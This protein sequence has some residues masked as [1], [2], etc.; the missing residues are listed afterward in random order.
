MSTHWLR[1]E[2]AWLHET[3][4]R[5]EMFYRRKIGARKD[6]SSEEI[7]NLHKHYATMPKK[8]LMALIPDRGWNSILF[9][10][11]QILG[12]D[13]SFGRGRPTG[14]TFATYD[15]HTSYADILF[16]E[17]MGFLPSCRSTNWVVRY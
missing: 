11:K 1:V 6:W 9:Y 10:A 15:I 14:E 2:V 3:W 12:I 16:M 13:R 17:Q 5:E 7:A 4:G 8:Q